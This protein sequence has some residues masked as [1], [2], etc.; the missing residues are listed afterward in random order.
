[1]TGI[2]QVLADVSGVISAVDD[3]QLAATLANVEAFSRTLSDNRE[4]FNTILTDISGVVGAIDPE[5]I[6]SAIESAEQFTRALG[7]RS[8]DTEVIIANAVSLTA[9][10]NESADRIDGVLQAAE[11]FLGTAT[12]GV[13]NGLFDD[14]RDAVA[15][16]RVLAEN[17]DTR[18]GEITQGITRATGPAL[19]EYRQ[20]AD[21]GRRTL[22]EISR[23]VRSLER[24]P[25]QLLFGGQPS[26]P[27]YRER[28]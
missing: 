22:E 1:V 12:E 19:Q 9:K 4:N 18:T 8:A 15:A 14:I 13:E 16:I 20:L 26:V 27:E 17:L 21:D 25:Q 6:A 23:A 28:R 7:D 11:N 3:E 24:N 5:R 2:N 10:L